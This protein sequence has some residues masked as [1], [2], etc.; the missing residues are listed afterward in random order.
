MAR[1]KSDKL[2]PFQKLMT[3]MASGKAV[4]ID[5]I[6]ATLGKEIHMYRLSTYI[7]LM[8]TNAN[9]VVKAIK[10]GRK[11]TAYQIMN[12]ADVKDYLKRVGATSFTPGQ[13]QKI[14]KAKTKAAPA[15]APKVAKLKDLKAE[16]VAKEVTEEVMEVTE[17]TDKETA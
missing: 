4:T 14:V 12:V 6:D 10:D 9:A 5:E 11:I 2:A 13:S 16:P 7:W 15:P 8:K 1:G 17:V 3:V